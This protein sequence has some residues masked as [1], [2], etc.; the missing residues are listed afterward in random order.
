MGEDVREFIVS[1]LSTA[2]FLEGH[3]SRMIDC[4]NGRY[5]FAYDDTIEPNLELYSQVW[6]KCM[7]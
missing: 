3:G 6:D 1:D 2:T 7:F 4:R 5:V